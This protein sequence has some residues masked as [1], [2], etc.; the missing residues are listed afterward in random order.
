MC[1]E[2]NKIEAEYALRGM[3]QP[4]GVAEFKL[5]KAIPK[6]I[7][8]ELPTIEEIELATTKAI[9]NGGQS[10]KNEKYK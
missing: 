9:S 7:K 10:A 5:S 6:D 2:R 4:I 3:S 8:S 1:K